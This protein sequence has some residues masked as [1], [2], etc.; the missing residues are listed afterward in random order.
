[1]MNGLMMGGIAYLFSA[2]LQGLPSGVLAL[3][4]V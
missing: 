4:A 2:H 3:A 1:M